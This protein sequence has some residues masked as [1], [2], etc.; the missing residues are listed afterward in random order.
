WCVL[1]ARRPA[2]QMMTIRQRLSEAHGQTFDLAG[3]PS[4]AFPLPEALLD[5]E[6]FPGLSA[7]KVDRLHSVARA[8]LDGELD[9]GRLLELGPDETMSRL[10]SIKGIGPF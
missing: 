3:R 2:R 5:V 1:A 9:S 4:A 7:D 6:S 8:A 10:Q